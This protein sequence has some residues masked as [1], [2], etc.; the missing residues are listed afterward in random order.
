MLVTKVINRFCCLS[1]IGTILIWFALTPTAKA[2]AGLYYIVGTNND[3][4]LGSF[5]R[6]RGGAQDVQSRQST[7][8]RVQE[9]VNKYGELM[10]EKGMLAE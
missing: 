8:M 2:R 10:V 6:Y 4:D 1:L 9:L 5:P 3:R 7:M